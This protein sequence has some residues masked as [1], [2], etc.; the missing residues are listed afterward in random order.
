M[1]RRATVDDLL[2]A[3]R[4]GLRRLT[5]DEARAAAAR[6]A[7]IV[8][9]R[10]EAQ[11][12]RDGAVPGA[13]CHPRNV[14]EWRCDPACEANDPRLAD[15]RLMLIVLC[16]GGYQ[17]SLAAANLKAIG[18]ARATDVIGGFRAWRAAGLPVEPG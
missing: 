1:E 7:V 2:A 12:R 4:S 5:P 17:S 11:R 18:F 8:D 10:T 3:A 13:V 9:V 16:D 6:G 15:P 14:L